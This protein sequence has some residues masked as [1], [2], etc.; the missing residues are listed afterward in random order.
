MEKTAEKEKQ[1]IEVGSEKIKQ[2]NELASDINMALIEVCESSKEIVEGIRVRP[3][4]KI[5]CASIISMISRSL[6]NAQEKADE[7]YESISKKKEEL[8]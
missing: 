8:E 4:D 2:W 5:N 7:L 3:Y 6:E 1:M